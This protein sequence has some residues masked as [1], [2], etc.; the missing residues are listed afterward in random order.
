MPYLAPFE[1]DAYYHLYNHAVGDENLFRSAENYRF[2]LSRY[3]HYTQRILNTYAYCLMPNHFHFLIR[4]KPLEDISAFFESLTKYQGVH[5]ASTK[6]ISNQ[7]GHQ[8]GSWLGSYSKAYN[9]RFNRRGRLFI[10]R[11]RRIKVTDQNY[12][13]RLIPYIHWNPVHHGFV[14]FPEDWPYSSYNHLLHDAAPL[15]DTSSVVRLFGSRQVVKKAHLQAP[16]LDFRKLE[17]Y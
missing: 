11:V 14:D 6:S 2:F 10:E 4:V 1:P 16:D 13:C 15:L 7:I 3:T 5:V 12:L 17:F 8:L 9:K